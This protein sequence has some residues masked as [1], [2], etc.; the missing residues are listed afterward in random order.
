[1]KWNDQDPYLSSIQREEIFPTPPKTFE[2][3]V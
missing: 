1:M 3:K 2:M